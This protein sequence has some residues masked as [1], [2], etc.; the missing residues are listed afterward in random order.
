M[1]TRVHTTHRRPVK[2]QQ[3]LQR[4]YNHS[5][6]PAQSMISILEAAAVHQPDDQHSCKSG[7]SCARGDQ[8]PCTE[9]ERLSSKACIALGK[10]VH[11]I[12]GR[13]LPTKIYCT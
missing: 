12:Q 7:R 10:P 2:A 3:Q 13:R 1:C 9:L 8:Q 4:P 6:G 11:C 5:F